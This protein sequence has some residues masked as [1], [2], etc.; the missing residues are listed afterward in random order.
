M[1]R[2]TAKIL[3][4]SAIKDFESFF[5]N[6]YKINIEY[7]NFNNLA[8]KGNGSE[9]RIT[10]PNDFLNMQINT[11]EDKFYTLFLL[12]HE[13]AH[14]VNKHNYYKD[15]TSIE[16]LS[17]E[18]WADF[19]GSIISMSIL[20]LGQN[21]QSYLE[22]NVSNRNETLK[23]IFHAYERLY[24]IFKNTDAS[25]KYASSKDRLLTVFTGMLS[26]L[27]RRDMSV[28]HNLISLDKLYLSSSQRWGLTLIKLIDK[29][30]CLYKVMT[31]KNENN[32]QRKEVKGTAIKIHKKL[33][34]NN[35]QITEG[36][37]PKLKWILGT[38]FNRP[39]YMGKAQ[40]YLDSR[41]KYSSSA[42][43]ET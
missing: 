25:S 29:E 5:T 37:H 11:D 2:I 19:F 34:G 27:V 22:I 23:S 28:N 20:K 9:A 26:F 16:S 35:S 42:P 30:S 43:N 39:N 12:G 8:V 38:D 41:K 15:S 7:G 14:Y 3:I 6:G 31:S 4:E 36:I 13:I 18:V 17:M 32:V 33:M 40:E 24:E 1:S 21:F 10:I